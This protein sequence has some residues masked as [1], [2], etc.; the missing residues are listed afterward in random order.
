[1]KKT[2]KQFL[3]ILEGLGFFKM[4]HRSEMMPGGMDMERVIGKLP[5]P[6]NTI[7]SKRAKKIAQNLNPNAP[8][9][10]PKKMTRTDLLKK[11]R[12]YYD[13]NGN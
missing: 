8:S 11:E 10:R 2:F 3:N 4:G 5:T 9:Y 12:P 1:M 6:K 7:R 13:Q